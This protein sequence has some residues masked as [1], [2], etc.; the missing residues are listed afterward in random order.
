M[1][2]GHF[3]QQFEKSRKTNFHEIEL[4]SVFKYY[5]LPIVFVTHATLTNLWFG[6]T[7]KELLFLICLFSVFL[8]LEYLV[9]S[10][11]NVLILRWEVESFNNA[12]KSS[13]R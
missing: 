13:S 10:G 2:Q 12:Y 9:L 1:F 7:S 4:E 3:F 8:L 5:L 11:L 6:Q